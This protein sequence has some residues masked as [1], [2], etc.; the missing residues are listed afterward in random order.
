VCAVRVF[1]LS[2]EENGGGGCVL[3]ISIIVYIVV[4]VGEKGVKAV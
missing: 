1:V 2:G 4:L 3:Q